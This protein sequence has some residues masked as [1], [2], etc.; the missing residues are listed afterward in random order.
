ML[1]PE[2]IVA[3]REFYESHLAESVLKYPYVVATAVQKVSK[4]LVELIDINKRLDIDLLKESIAVEDEMYHP[5][6]F[7][8]IPDIKMSCSTP[9]KT[10]E[11]LRQILVDPSSPLELVM[12]VHAVFMN[13]VYDKLPLQVPPSLLYDV[14]AV[15]SSSYSH[16]IAN[17]IRKDPSQ[18]KNIKQQVVQDIFKNEL[19]YRQGKLD[20]SRKEKLEAVPRKDEIGIIRSPF[21]GLMAP[22]SAYP[23][24]RAADNFIPDDTSNYT[25]FAK[26]HHLPLVAGP[27]GNAGGLMLIPSVCADLS[28]EEMKQYGLA[29][30]AYLVGGG[31]HAF[32][33][34][35]S[36]LAKVGIPHQMGK[37]EPTLPE[38]Y[39]NSAAYQEVKHTLNRLLN[40][41]IQ[42]KILE[43]SHFD[44]KEYA[45]LYEVLTG[46]TFQLAENNAICLYEWSQFEKL[47]EKPEAAKAERSVVSA[48]NRNTPSLVNSAIQLGMYALSQLGLYKYP[49]RPVPVR[50]VNAEIYQDEERERQVEQLLKE[51][52]TSV[53]DQMQRLAGHYLKS[54]PQQEAELVR[55]FLIDLVLDSAG[56]LGHDIPGAVKK[57][58]DHIVDVER[59]PRRRFAEV[60]KLAK[61]YDEG[62]WQRKVFSHG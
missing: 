60:V 32:H 36:V 57:Q 1:T 26:Q 43:N 31:N 11:D 19:F 40:D 54:F 62:Y 49:K 4:A 47:G 8:R 58:Y 55:K 39:K 12:H 37:Y 22:Q 51:K 15:A 45:G 48:G 2:Q 17:K 3:T 27:S 18:I 34:V 52:G 16:T 56:K 25:Q 35:G 44:V 6:Y 41:Y 33:E 20:R 9:L 28:L 50:M 53:A 38:S 61:E 24:L 59:N 23:H 46:D 13:K 42:Q 14:Q 5:D 29:V 10:L 30:M 7:G 21:F